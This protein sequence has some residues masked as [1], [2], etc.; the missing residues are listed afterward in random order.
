MRLGQRLW[1]TWNFL[2]RVSPMAALSLQLRIRRT[3][4][5]VNSYMP[6]RHGSRLS[7]AA[8]RIPL[9]MGEKG[10]LKAARTL[11]PKVIIPIH[12]GIRPRAPIFAN[13]TIGRAL[14]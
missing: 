2:D 5:P 10:A 6:F 9:T 12:L 7:V 4:R 13:L 1:R 14:H 8:F 3:F 11:S